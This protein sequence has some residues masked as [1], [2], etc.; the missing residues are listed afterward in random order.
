MQKSHSL[1]VR[2]ASR[3]AI[4]AKESGIGDDLGI[5]V[6]FVLSDPSLLAPRPIA[7]FC[8]PGG[9]FAKGYFDLDPGG[10]DGLSF[11]EAMAE[12]GHV[13]V[14]IDH[15]GVGDSDRPADGFLLDPHTVARIDDLAVRKARGML[16]E[17]LAG[18]GAVPDVRPVGLG[19]SMGGMLAAL[20]QA[21]HRS[22]D[23]LGILG[24]NTFGAIAILMEA[25]KPLADD[26]VETRRSL[27]PLLR[28][29]GAAGY[30][31]MVAT[32]GPTDIFEQGDAPGKAA[33]TH[34]RSPLLTVCGMFSMIP[35][36]WKPEA[37]RIDVPLYLA[38][39][40]DD[41]CRNPH[42]V[43]SCFTASPDVTLSVIKDTGHNHF[44]FA[45]RANLFARIDVWA[46]TLPGQ[47]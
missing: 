5:S 1:P 44:A 36:S 12:R 43:P 7:F 6:T 42:D 46:R 35:G 33:V 9:S 23:A 4:T 20:M 30:K 34:V 2:I 39:G 16:A 14:L 37:A 10:S 26:P 40:D 21:D 25:L 3:I 8:F 29:A 27:V 38:F 28:K 47:G 22:F 17:G 19:H 31:D 41:L 13:C 11:A 18:Y 24:S 32:P 45:S 15:P